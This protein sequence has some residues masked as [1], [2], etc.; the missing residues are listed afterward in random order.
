MDGLCLLLRGASNHSVVQGKDK[1]NSNCDGCRLDA[2]D[3]WNG[4][5]FFQVRR[6]ELESLF[7]HKS[8]SVLSS[9]GE[10]KKMD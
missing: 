4:E 8:K 3:I 1:C 2:D 9:L 5:G 10:R 6:S 7:S